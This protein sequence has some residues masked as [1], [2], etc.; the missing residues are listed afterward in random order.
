MPFRS[1][2][3]LRYLIEDELPRQAKTLLAKAN[4]WQA[5]YVEYKRHNMVVQDKA[6]VDRIVRAMT[7]TEC[8]SDL[9]NGRPTVVGPLRFKLRH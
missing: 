4:V 1:L 7:E 2:D 9:D 3:D 6:H 8:E 5:R